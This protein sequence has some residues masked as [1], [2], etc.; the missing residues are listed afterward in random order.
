MQ[1]GITRRP[2][3][4]QR[5]RFLFLVIAV[6]SCC[7]PQALLAQTFQEKEARAEAY[8]SQADE[9][10]SAGNY[11][12]AIDNYF[13]AAQIAGKRINLSRAYMGLSLCY[14]YLNG[15]E[16]SKKYILKA[17]ELDPQKEVSSLFHPQTYV[18]LFDQV[19]KENADKLSLIKIEPEAEAPEAG[20]EEA[21]KAEQR[22]AAVP[23]MAPE[24]SKVGRWEVEVHFSGWSISPA[25]ALLQENLTDRVSDEILENVTDQLNPHYAGHLVP[26]SSTQSLSLSSNGSNYGLGVRYYPLGK[27]GSFSVGFSLEKTNI[28]ISMEGPVTQNYADGSVATVESTSTVTTNPFT[29]NLSFEWDFNPHWRVTPYFVLGLGFGPFGGDFNFVYTGTY[30]RG[31]SQATVQG[32]DNK[33]FDQL[34]QEQDIELDLFL[35]LQAAIGVKGE[36]YKNFFVLGEIGFW[37]GLVFRGGV[38]Y[39]F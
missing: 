21:Q 12:K 6:L 1:V 5:L 39:R 27:Q 32:E 15:T 2:N 10:Y 31:S 37:D 17:L 18:D 26:S 8:L 3:R 14:F 34:R 33:T 7:L 28:T 9:L 22:A 16:N 29:A 23:G 24:E 20:Q 4:Q 19:K 36:I 11:P 25:K 35:I 13:Q 38:G 30:R